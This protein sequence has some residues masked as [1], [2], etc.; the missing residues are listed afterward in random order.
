M[1]TDL[2]WFLLVAAA[3]VFFFVFGVAGTLG[4]EIAV[5]MIG[6]LGATAAVGAPAAA[7][8]AAAWAI[9]VFYRRIL[10]L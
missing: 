6:L 7:A 10:R 5:L 2:P 3:A 8:V 1:R 9:L 4:E